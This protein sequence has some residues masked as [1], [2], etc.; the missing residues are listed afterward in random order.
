MITTTIK[1]EDDTHKKIRIVSAFTGKTII[2]I[3]S[4]LINKLLSRKINEAEEDYIKRIKKEY[5]L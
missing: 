1:I 3:M 5:D 2:F 4:K